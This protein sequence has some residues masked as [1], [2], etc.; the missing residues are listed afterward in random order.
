LLFF[1]ARAAFRAASV[2]GAHMVCMPVFSRSRAESRLS[3]MGVTM[4]LKIALISA[5]AVGL[6]MSTGAAYAGSSNDLLIDQHG[7]NN[8]AT[9]DQSNAHNSSIGDPSIGNYVSQ[10]QVGLGDAWDSTLSITQVGGYNTV[11]AGVPPNYWGIGQYDGSNYLTI[12]QGYGLDPGYDPQNNVTEVHQ[13]GYGGSYPGFYVNQTSITQYYDDRIGVI[14]Q[15]FQGSS[16]A[17]VVSIN[18]HGSGNGGNNVSSV[19]QTGHDNTLSLPMTNNNVGP[20]NGVGAFTNQGA[21]A[22]AANPV[23]YGVPNSLIPAGFTPIGQATVTQSGDHNGISFSIDGGGNLFGF[24]QVGNGNSISGG[25]TGGYA[26]EIAIAQVG[27]DINTINALMSGSYNKLGAFQV[28]DGSNTGWANLSGT[29]NQGALVQV[30]ES[31]GSNTGTVQT[32]AS[33]SDNAVGVLQYASNGGS[34][35]GTAT[36]NG[37]DNIVGVVQY[38][39]GGSN[40]GNVG[41]ASGSSNVAVLGQYASGGGSN[42]A[43]VAINGNN[44]N[45]LTGTTPSSYSGGHSASVLASQLGYF[46]PH[47]STINSE[48]DG[49]SGETNFLQASIGSLG[50]QIGSYNLLTPGLMTQIAN[51]G[52]NSLSMNVTG[53]GNLFST[54]QDGSGAGSNTLNATVLGSSNELAVAQVTSGGTNVA[55]VTQNGYGNSAGVVQV[56]TNSATFNQ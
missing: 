50:S 35:N 55:Y 38:A 4:N 34:N 22:I 19:T 41:V 20:D 28:G 11:G 1:E 40:S 43:G 47:G 44:N 23:S 27:T 7:T 21:A 48:A 37:S 52:T 8:T 42:S 32:G 5:T 46:N 13:F 18:Q 24:E 17:N 16:G 15:Q 39:S 14:S 10:G 30:S 36:A 45:V 2:L 54:L 29:D 12:Y 53:D 25:I 26:D 56:G 51:G 9:T 33:S 3:I 31:G 6:L 49:L